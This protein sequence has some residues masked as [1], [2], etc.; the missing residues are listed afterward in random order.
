LRT[1][2]VLLTIMGFV[3]LFVTLAFAAVLP[4]PFGK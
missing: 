1:V 3:G 2:T 4:F